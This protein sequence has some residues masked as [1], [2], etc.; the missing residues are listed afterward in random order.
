MSERDTILASLYARWINLTSRVGA[1]AQIVGSDPAR[2]PGGGNYTPETVE[3]WAADAEQVTVLLDEL[4]QQTYEA[5]G[6]LTADPDPQPAQPGRSCGSCEHWRVGRDGGA[7]RCYAAGSPF[8]LQVTRGHM[9]ACPLH[10]LKAEYDEP[11]A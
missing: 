2:L 10:A 9:A 4:C 3:A 11:P 8:A 6:R 1:C 7:E 5:L